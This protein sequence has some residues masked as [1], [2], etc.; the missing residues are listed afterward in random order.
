MKIKL[1]LLCLFVS[2]GVS[3]QIQYIN[4]Y[5]YSY[6]A[7]E[8][9]QVFNLPN[10]CD[11]NV[12][13]RYKPALKPGSMFWDSCHNIRYVFYNNSWHQD[14][15]GGGGGGGTSFDSL[16]AQGGGFH[17]QPYNDARYRGLFDT[18]YAHL[19]MTR[20]WGYKISDS[21][22][23]LIALKLTIGD[24][25]YSHFLMTRAWGYKI[26]DSIFGV[27]NSLLNAKV[28]NYSG[29]SKFI[30]SGLDAAKPSAS[31]GKGFWY[32]TDLKYMEY[33]DGSTWIK[34]TD[35]TGFSYGLYFQN[36]G[37]GYPQL[38]KVNDSTEKIRT[39]TAGSNITIDSTTTA[40]TYIINSTGGGGG[41]G[42]DTTILPGAALKAVYSG[43]PAKTK[44]LNVDTASDIQPGTMSAADHKIIHTAIYYVNDSAGAAVDSF[45][46]YDSTTHTYHHKGLLLGVGHS[47]HSTQLVI[48]DDIDTM[49]ITSRSHLQK[50]LDSLNTKYQLMTDSF[51]VKSMATRGYVGKIRDSLGALIG[52]AGGL[53]PIANHKY[54][55]VS[56]I[57]GSA[58]V[59]SAV[60]QP[61]YVVTDYP[62]IINDSSADISSGLQALANFVPRGSV[63]FFPPGKYRVDNTVSIP[64]SIQLLGNGEPISAHID[65]PGSAHWTDGATT[66]YYTAA[67]GACFKM[68]GNGWS[69]H[70]ICIRQSFGVTPTSSVGIHA[71]SANDARVSDIGIRGF[72]VNVHIVNGFEYALDRVV[73]YG[74]KAYNL[75]VE[76]TAESDAGDNKITNC[77]FWAGDYDMQSH[78]LWKSGGGLS[79]QGDKFN[80]S[81]AGHTYKYAFEIAFD[82]TD[83]DLF[84]GSGFSMENMDSSGIFIHNKVSFGLGIIENGEIGFA[85]GSYGHKFIWLQHTNPVS[86]N[87]LV[88]NNITFGGG[89]TDTC[90]FIDGSGNGNINVGTNSYATS[91]PVV[92]NSGTHIGVQRFPYIYPLTGQTTTFDFGKGNNAT[93]SVIS[94]D[95]IHFANGI[96]N[97]PFSIT[98][99]QNGAG[100]G[101]I[102]FPSAFNL[103]NSFQIIQP[104]T[105]SGESYIISGYSN[106]G[107]SSCVITRITRSM[108]LGGISYLDQFQG[109]GY[110]ANLQWDPTNHSLLIGTNAAIN[111]GK[112]Q[113]DA[114]TDANNNVPQLMSERH[115]SGT[116]GAI[117][118]TQK[119]RGTKQTPTV[120]S[121]AD[122]GYLNEHAM[123][124]GG[125]YIVGAV[126]AGVQDSAASS[127]SMPMSMIWGTGRVNNTDPWGSIDFMMKLDSRGRF[128]IGNAD[129]ID[130]ALV[131]F[132]RG[133]FGT[134]NNAAF[135]QILSI[136]RGTIN[137]WSPAATTTAIYSG[138]GIRAPIF[139]SS[140]LQTYTNAPTL[141]IEGAPIA[142]T[143]V[144]ITNPYSLW[145]N[146]GSIFLGGPI[147][148]AFL[149]TKSTLVATDSIL[150]KDAAGN[151]YSAPQSIFTGTPV[152]IQKA[153]DNDGPG[154]A[155]LTKDDTV[156]GGKKLTFGISSNAMTGFE[157]NTSSTFRISSPNINL[158][159]TI[160]FKS[161]LDV[162][163]ANYSASTGS[164]YFE[165]PVITAN[166]TFT[167]PTAGGFTLLKIINRNTAAFAWTLPTTARDAGGNTIS[168]LQNG[169]SYEF[170]F[171]GS[172]WVMTGF[173]RLST[174]GIYGAVRT[175][176]TTGSITNDDHYLAIDASAGNVTLTLPAAS[177][178]FLGSTGNN[179]GQEFI[180][181]RIDNSGNTVTVQRNGT[182]GTDIINGSSSFTL[183]TQ[184][185]S[186]T[187][188][189]IT[190]SAFIQN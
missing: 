168:T 68:T 110:D 186:K 18:A 153:I 175:I 100:T 84:M 30:G 184:Y 137:N 26:S 116:Q 173:A 140:A 31:L 60:A 105:R 118:G 167:F 157:V 36:A 189:A 107:G 41:S 21:L 146:S 57:T 104:G 128:S 143:N 77:W 150:V 19:L 174:S 155:I 62:G 34:I 44:T 112:G 177:T 188:T 39:Y 40:D 185:S 1:L 56:N 76:D 74:P 127:F 134:Y 69:M 37:A 85:R 86:I 98:V 97:E 10:R 113:I 160:V 170:I 47:H 180:F 61:Y 32:S 8:S 152:T 64:Q 149:P 122:Y 46:Y 72:N 131:S 38:F 29:T 138:S 158:L 48:Y 148:H 12:D 156:L 125:N 169:C 87:G 133:A 81:T 79:I 159:G 139:T 54:L 80:G 6:N 89:A 53:T 20:Q 17:T 55:G 181:S 182:P 33:S 145:V 25:A 95:T 24:T 119:S 176:T 22:A 166:R 66:I 67:T 92:N 14:S 91:F 7:L 135:G 99:T 43:S 65:P 190:S 9:R 109:P 13:A 171:N 58:A 136:V 5:G 108:P 52:A 154:G 178:C 4:A 144:T 42:T 161:L 106:G 123:H 183:T 121:V 63:L 141:Y 126:E 111:Y 117:N 114:T 179:Q 132:G 3:A 101:T 90:I 147:I 16:T 163:D 96:E 94:T 151:E 172:N 82:R 102:F 71:D 142:S 120:T 27:M 115:F 187:L 49:T 73:F 28:D 103:V 130:S 129:K 11:T 124:D 164:L 70:N 35:P 93:H 45:T 78:L 83:V 75:I 15:T 165:L 88:I 59:P 23:A 50:V 51:G 162:T 2:A